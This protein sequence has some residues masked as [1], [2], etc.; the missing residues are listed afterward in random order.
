MAL[1]GV[2]Q[3]SAQATIDDAVSK[4][5][6]L[7]YKGVRI[8]EATVGG[9]L[10]K[11]EEIVSRDR[12]KARITYPNDSP[13]KGYIIVETAR[14]RWEYNPSKN[15]VRKTPRRRPDSGMMLGGLS[16]GV[17]E[18]RL[19]AHLGTPDTV[20]GRR[21]ATVKV[22][23]RRGN[24]IQRLNIDEAT[25][26]ILR[27][28]QFGPEDRKLAG[29]YLQ[30][31]DFS[32][33]FAAGEFAPPR[34]PGAKIIDRPPDFG[35]DWSV[36]TPAWLPPNFKEVGRGFRRLENRPVVMLHYSDGSKNFSVFQG[37]GPR[38]PRFGESERPGYQN[39]TR[40]F[41][42]LWFIGLGRVEK[43]TLDRVLNSIK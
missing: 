14:E 39:A 4:Q 30:R 28:E 6:R 42:G 18:G 35:V 3:E 2:A 16:H 8:V 10:V 26:M 27:A 38:P 24:M 9:K 29:Y 15:E 19:K 31:I 17:R 13:R 36:R 34:P 20:A 32:P 1:P 11:L 12:D 37:R 33:N 21:T 43:S 25:G 7:R 23:D 5:P 22:I 41:E 40:L